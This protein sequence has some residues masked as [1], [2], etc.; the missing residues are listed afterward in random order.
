MILSIKQICLDKMRYKLL[1][2][3]T[4]LHVDVSQMEAEIVLNKSKWT[5]VPTAIPIN[6]TVLSWLGSIQIAT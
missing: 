3:W 2:V 4:C 6:Q 1:S 5:F